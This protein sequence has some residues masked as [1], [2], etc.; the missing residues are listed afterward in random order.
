QILPR[1]S[2]ALVRR[3]EGEI[4][5]KG[6][7]PMS[8]GWMAW[9]CLMLAMGAPGGADEIVYINQKGFTI[10]ISVKPERRGDVRELILHLSRDQGKTWEIYGR[11]AP[12]KKGFDFFSTGDGLLYFSIAV[13]DKQGRQDPPDP[14][15]AEVGQKIC[16]DTV[17]PVMKIVSAE[18]VG[19]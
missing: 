10:P 17:K 8:T 19:G 18:R 14:Y 16:I 9:A 15:R 1:M 4:A 11:A 12:D 7:A 5:R 13:T 2:A 3:A 6:D